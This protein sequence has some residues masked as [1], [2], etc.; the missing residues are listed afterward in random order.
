MSF[1]SLEDASAFAL[2]VIA[3][4]SGARDITRAALTLYQW[5]LEAVP[6]YGRFAAGAAPASLADIPAVPVALFRDVRFCATDAPSVVYRTSGTTTGRRGEHWM[7][8]AGVYEAAALRWFQACLPGCPVEETLSLVT[9]PR[10]HPDSSLGHMI[11]HFSPDAR[12]FFDPARGVDLSSAWAALIAAERPVFIAATAFALADLFDRTDLRA[13]LPEGS[14][15]MV[16]GGF[17]GRHSELD[18]PALERAITERLGGVRAVG[19]Y[20]MTELSSQLWDT[21]EGFRAPPWLHAYAVD[22]LTGAPV[23]GEGLLRFVDLANWGSAL[24]IET[25]DLGTVTRPGDGLGDIVQ[26]RGRL[27]GAPPRGC[28]LTVEESREAAWT[29]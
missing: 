26:L 29:R 16:T 5:Q 15:L 18:G 2:D 22:P 13:D 4:P 9:P 6:A 8:H 20:G 25:M 23:E 24:A 17:K 21:G 27:T 12:W 28:S 1:A 7:P 11:A 19:E 3:A 14:V 10:S